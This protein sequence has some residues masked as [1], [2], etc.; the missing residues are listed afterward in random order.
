MQD[1]SP[2]ALI[3]SFVAGLSDFLTT[4]VPS[5]N[6]VTRPVCFESGAGAATLKFKADRDY[7]LVGWTHPSGYNVAISS[8]GR[9]SVPIAA[10][11]AVTDGIFWLSTTATQSNFC[12]AIRIPIPRGVTITVWISQA[13]GAVVLFL[14]EA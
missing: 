13:S 4:L 7:V 8:N 2:H 11:N 6:K 3:Q 10:G 5:A 12:N 9:A 1:V 14:E